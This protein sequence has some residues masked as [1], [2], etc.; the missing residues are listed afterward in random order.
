MGKDNIS[1]EERLLA[2]I[3]KGDKTAPPKAQENRS[4]SGLKVFFGR[5]KARVVSALP[6]PGKETDGVQSFD[7]IHVLKITNR[8]IGVLAAIL[9]LILIIDM[10]FPSH[11]VTKIYAS[12]SGT[13]NWQT[14]K[15]KVMP[16]DVFSIY[17]EAV[18]KR[19]IFNPVTQ[20]VLASNASGRPAQFQEATKDLSL[21]GIYWGETPEAM[22]ED[23]VAKKTYFLKRGDE[24][25]GIKV[26]DILKDRV[27]LQ[28]RTEEIE[29][30]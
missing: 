24:I 18:R 22:I 11:N 2:A 8:A 15:K 1:P 20:N 29:L 5:F 4:L 30:M 13:R 25:K 26:K 14:Q 23:T 12:T 28:Y 19:D 16:L 21:V 10:I 17:Q 7:I 9:L 3:E 6:L 27:I